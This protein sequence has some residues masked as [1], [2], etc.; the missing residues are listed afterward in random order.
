MAGVPTEFIYSPLQ[1]GR[2]YTHR[3]RMC[4]SHIRDIDLTS[5]IVWYRLQNNRRRK[6]SVTS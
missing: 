6:V 3:H 5:H 4:V 2:V 1:L